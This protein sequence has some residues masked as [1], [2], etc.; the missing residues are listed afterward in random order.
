MSARALRTDGLSSGQPRQASLTEYAH[1]DLC[2]FV[3][4]WGIEPA[5]FAP[6]VSPATGT[7][8]THRTDAAMGD[9]IQFATQEVLD[10]SHS[11]GMRPEQTSPFSFS[12]PLVSV[13]VLRSCNV[14]S[15]SYLVSRFF[16]SSFCCGN[17][18]TTPQSHFVS[19]PR[20]CL[21]RYC[22]RNTRFRRPVPFPAPSVPT[23][24]YSAS[25]GR[26]MLRVSGGGASA[27]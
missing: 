3:Q 5:T 22:V 11:S 2:A 1:N 16:S 18:N 4:P 27:L 6:G 25:R 7:H 26:H 12:P 21:L 15:H 17:T 9:A 14:I 20:R 13:A 23:D 8:P 24:R 19:G 10:A